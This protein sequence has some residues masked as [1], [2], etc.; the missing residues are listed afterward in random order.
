MTPVLKLLLF[1]TQRNPIVT[2]KTASVL[3]IGRPS[4]E[5]VGGWRTGR[6]VP[7]NDP[8]EIS[9]LDTTVWLLMK[10]LLLIEACFYTKL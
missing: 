5:A 6:R 8:A 3:R 4:H 1:S 7:F 10:P 2:T 9:E